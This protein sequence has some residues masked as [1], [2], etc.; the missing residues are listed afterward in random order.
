[1]GAGGFART[2]TDIVGQ[3]GEIETVILLDDRVTD[4]V[5][6]RC[7]TYKQYANEDTA[8]YPAISNNEARRA[9]LEELMR[10]QARIATIIHPSAYVSPTASI[11]TGVV[12]LPGAIVNAGAVIGAGAL[13]NCGAILDHDCRVGAYAHVRP[14]AVVAAIS[15]VPEES[16]VER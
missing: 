7:D 15:E 4:G 6:G 11:A 13:I 1:M 12:I 3:M 8:F 16:I 2:L 9:W 14:G 5:A 10:S